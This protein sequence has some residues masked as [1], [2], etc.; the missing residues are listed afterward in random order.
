MQFSNLCLC[1]TEHLP[2]EAEFLTL[3]CLDVRFNYIVEVSNAVR[4]N[5]RILLQGNI[6]K[7]PAQ[8]SFLGSNA[9]F[10]TQEVKFSDIVISTFCCLRRKWSISSSIVEFTGYE[11][12]SCSLQVNRK[13]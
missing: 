6:P 10:K 9:V 7:H 3:S 1:V 5:G 13:C 2:D 11:Y 8:K 4:D 12:C